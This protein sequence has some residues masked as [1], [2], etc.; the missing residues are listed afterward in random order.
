M[1]RNCEVCGAEFS[2]S[3]AKVRQGYGRFCSQECFQT[4]Q[5]NQIE[6][7][8]E[9]CG[10]RFMAVRAFVNKGQARYCSRSCY[11]VARRGI[12]KEGLR[13][14]LM[15]AKGHPI[16]PP[17]GV[18]LISRVVLYDKIGP[19]PHPCH[20][21]G[22]LVEWM[23]GVGVRDPKALLVDHVDLDATNDAPG[24]LEP[25]C[26]PCNSHRRLSGNSQLIRDDELVVV[27]ADGRRVRGVQ[28]E[29][30]FCGTAFVAAETQVKI[31][32]GRFCSRSCARSG[33]R[34]STAADTGRRKH[35]RTRPL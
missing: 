11:S 31:G 20:W 15:R 28:R 33:P 30:E 18:T 19:G 7:T 14:R 13:H 4:T 12:Q 6:R 1:R 24:N 8:C 5:R 9:A 23:P 2:A 22:T 26:N 16:A 34:P 35:R 29:C 10:V 27:K 25:S 32:R 3:P 21:C 17:S